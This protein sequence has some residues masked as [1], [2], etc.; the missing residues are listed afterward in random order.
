MHIYN[1]FIIYRIAAS[2]AFL[3]PNTSV[4]M[5]FEMLQYV[6]PSIAQ[7]NNRILI[8]FCSL[9]MV[10]KFLNIHHHGPFASAAGLIWFVKDFCAPF[11]V[12]SSKTCAKNSLWNLRFAIKLN[13]L[14]QK[15][16]EWLKTPQL[17]MF[18]ILRRISCI[19]FRMESAYKTKS[20]TE[21]NFGVIRN[22]MHFPNKKFNSQNH[23]WSV[24][25]GKIRYE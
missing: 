21:C 12:H 18:I 20:S 25:T 19:E 6:R 15:L 8:G 7:C 11:N 16:I 13:H 5:K 17:Q 24:S 4:F 2:S 14:I 9:L 1:R 3:H 22:R 10:D 23:F